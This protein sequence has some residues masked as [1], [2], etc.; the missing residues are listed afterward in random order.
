MSKSLVNLKALN[1]LLMNCHKYKTKLKLLCQLYDSFNYASEINGFLKSKEVERIHLKFCKFFKNILK[2]R[3]STSNTA[4]YAELGRHLL[5]V[6]LTRYV[7][8][9]KY[10]L[11]LNNTE[12]ILF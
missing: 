6:Y 8:I 1:V 2:V 4:V 10:W 3:T 12:N 9:V 11:K 5:R 7:N